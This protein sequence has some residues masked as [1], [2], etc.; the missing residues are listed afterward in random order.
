M[1]FLSSSA[2]RSAEYDPNSNELH[3]TFTSG[4][5]FTYFAVPAWKYAGLIAASSAGQYFNENI[6]DQHSSNR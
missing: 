2:I 6:R 1:V 5:S 4:G 3:I